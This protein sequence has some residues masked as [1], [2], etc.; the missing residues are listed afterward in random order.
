MSRAAPA[1]VAAA[2]AALD[3]AGEWFADAERLSSPN[4][5]ARPPGTAVDL[6]IIHGI[7]LPPGVFGGPW[8]RD[9]FLNRLDWDA[10]PYFNEIRGLK[11]SSHVFIERDGT[12]VQFVPL[13]LRA[14]HAGESRFRGRPRCNDFSVGIELEGTDHTPYEAAQYG[15]LAR[16]L[17]ALM[18]RFPGITPGRVAGHCHVAPSRKTDP[19][20]AFRWDRLGTLLGAPAGWGPAATDP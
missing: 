12:L 5:D 14:W 16:V 4:C 6:A 7:S 20:P 10:H 15:T 8:V 1:G 2:P 18:T 3:A 19:G 9:L 11:V 13:S 17:A